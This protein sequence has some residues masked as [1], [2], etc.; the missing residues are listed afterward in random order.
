M[1][2][3]TKR[4]EKSDATRA[5]SVSSFVVRQQTKQGSWLRLRVTLASYSTSSGHFVLCLSHVIGCEPTYHPRSALVSSTADYTTR[6]INDRNHRTLSQ[7]VSSSQTTDCETI[8][9]PTKLESSTAA[10]HYLGVSASRPADD[11]LESKTSVCW[12]TADLYLAWTGSSETAT[13]RACHWHRNGKRP[14]DSCEAGEWSKPYRQ[15]LAPDD[16]TGYHDVANCT[17]L[18]Q[19]LNGD[20]SYDVTSANSTRQSTYSVDVPDA[21]VY[22]N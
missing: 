19:L 5:S 3:A 4:S 22:E 10:E 16:V 8:L 20:L 1:I 7:N 13:N 14:P 11:V 18:Q 15:R 6:L 2:V 12:T 17:Q 9:L 21:R